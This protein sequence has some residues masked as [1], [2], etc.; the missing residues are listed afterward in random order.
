M[1]RRK[2]ASTHPLANRVAS[3]NLSKGGLTV[4]VK[5]VPATDIGI[6][7]G[8]LLMTQRKLIESGFDELLETGTSA[9]ST[10][11]DQPEES[12]EPDGVVPPSSAIKT[13]G[14]VR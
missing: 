2:K 13:V 8:A 4:E 6:V 14:F 10:P 11:I 9:H 7:A 3:V 1:T 12:D 5:D